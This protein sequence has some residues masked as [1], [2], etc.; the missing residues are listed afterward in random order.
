M[1]PNTLNVHFPGFAGHALQSQLGARGFSVAT[2][3]GVGAAAP[4]HVLLAM[5]CSDARARSSLRFSLSAKTSEAS[6]DALIEALTLISAGKA[7][8]A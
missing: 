5:G 3:A 1:L 4:S 8:R 2:A 7:V 6:V